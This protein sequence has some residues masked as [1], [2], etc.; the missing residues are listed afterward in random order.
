LSPYE[1]WVGQG[2][3]KIVLVIPGRSSVSIATSLLP[4]AGFVL[5]VVQSHLYSTLVES[6]SNRIKD[7]RI[8]FFCH[9]DN[10]IV[11]MDWRKV[12]PHRLAA[13]G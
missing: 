8:P 10:L 9:V 4:Q 1:D 11:R 7:Q 12:K 5:P 3:L 6:S 13:F 2:I